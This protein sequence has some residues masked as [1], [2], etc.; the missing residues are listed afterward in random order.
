MQCENRYKTILRRKRISDKNNSTSGS[1]RVKVSFENEIKRIAA[2]DDSVQPEVLQ[3]ANN[4]VVN[5]KDTNMSKAPDKKKAKCN[6][7]N[8]L[9]E[10]HKKKETKKQERHEE[11]MK[12]LRSFLEKENTYKDS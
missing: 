1:K 10:I 9:L 7:L 12:L 2:I 4:V 5:V 8:T 6:I 3:S 11:K